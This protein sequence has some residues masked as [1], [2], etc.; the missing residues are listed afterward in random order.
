MES[1]K[2]FSRVALVIFIFYFVYYLYTGFI[3]QVPGLGDSWDY[4]IPISN[5]ILNNTFLS[6][7]HV[8][9]PQWYYPGSAEAINSLLIF[10]HIPLTFSNLLAVLVLFFVCWKLAGVF[11]LE[12][13]ESIFFASTIVTLN[14]FVRW[15]NAVSVD[16]WL[17]IFFLLGIVL[18]ER[19]KK[20]LLYFLQLGF[21]L[22]M[23]IGTKFSGWY[24]LL[25]LFALYGRSLA[26]RLTVKGIV[27]FFVP[28]STLG[29]FWYARNLI[30]FSNPFY[31]LALLNFPSKMYF[32]VKVWNVILSQPRSFI[33]AFFAEY[34][35]WVFSLPVSIIFLLRRLRKQNTKVPKGI[36]KL[37]TLGLLSTIVFLISPSE[38]QP[39][40][41]VSSFRYSYS[42][43]IPLILT[44]FLLAKVYKKLDFVYLLS[45]A[46]MI[47]VTSFF[48]YPKL[49]IIYAPLTLAAI[50]LIDRYKDS[51][52]RKL[53]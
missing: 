40:I 31:P 51:L 4:H 28:F 39:W 32:P 25:I 33:D 27:V 10:I 43:F 21:V 34:K 2:L 42:A 18:L 52:E 3:N 35:V 12:Y 41:I 37:I 30:L 49:V 9:L 1:S 11:G 6:P 14:V 38:K 13:Y 17:A 47:M 44:V 5:M 53:S 26:K 15:Y 29:F 16:V 7:T 23:L 8:K 24:M 50:Y 45:I 48:Y 22:G 46:S 36:Y 19:P 20:S